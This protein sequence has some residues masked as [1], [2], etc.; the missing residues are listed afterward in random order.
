MITKENTERINELMQD[1]DFVKEV[2][3]AGSEEGI[4]ELF[5]QKGVLLTKEDLHYCEESAKNSPEFGVFF[6]DDELSEDALEAVSGG[7]WFRKALG[8]GIMILG[9]GVAASTG[10]LGAAFAGTLITAGGMFVHGPH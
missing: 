4:I 3:S 8:I 5:A 7:G 10:G 2:F 9:V 6:Q 1:G